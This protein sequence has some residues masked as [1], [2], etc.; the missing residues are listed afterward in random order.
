MQ[1]QSVRALFSHVMFVDADADSFMLSNSPN[2]YFCTKRLFKGSIY[3]SFF[4]QHK[5]VAFGCVICPSYGGDYRK[6]RLLVRVALQLGG[7][8]HSSVAG[9][10]SQRTGSSPRLDHVEFLV[11]KVVLGQ[12]FFEYLGLPYQF[13]FHQLLHTH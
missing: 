3:I 13:S 8:C 7:P 9:F 2:S 12:V 5:M 4:A 10:A 1:L 11:E 6:L